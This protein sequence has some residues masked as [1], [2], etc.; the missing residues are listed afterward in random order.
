MFS[1]EPQSK[2]TCD[3]G[4]GS[5]VVVA[6]DKA[7]EMPDPDP[8]SIV[9]VCEPT[10]EADGPIEIVEPTCEPSTDEAPEPCVSALRFII[11]E[12]VAP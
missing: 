9:E 2:S 5:I 12:V 7:D 10:T 3:A 6:L 11:V 4:G 1:R 8:D